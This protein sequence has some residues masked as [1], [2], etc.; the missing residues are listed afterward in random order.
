MGKLSMRLT[1]AKWFRVLQ[2]RAQAVASLRGWT[3][4]ND[5]P[6]VNAQLHTEAER[7]LG[8]ELAKL[9]KRERP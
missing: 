1:N 9:V 8:S 4:P 7:Q 3:Y 5:D 6:A 2:A